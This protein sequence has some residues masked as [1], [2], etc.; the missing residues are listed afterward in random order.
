MK[1]T[2]NSYDD[3][4][5]WL[6]DYILTVTDAKHITDIAIND[7]ND[8]L[9]GLDEHHEQSQDLHRDVGHDWN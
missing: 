2:F 9:K 7:I 4:P 8:F 5:L 3:M 1:Q 6:I